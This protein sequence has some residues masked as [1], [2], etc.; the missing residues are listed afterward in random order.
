[1]DFLFGL[2][3]WAF[4]TEPTRDVIFCL[5]VLRFGENILSFSYFN[6]LTHVKK[7]GVITHSAGL[8]QIVSNHD[9]GVSLL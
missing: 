1:M 9:N 5:F 8:L 3:K 6:H 7:R 2:L 4:L